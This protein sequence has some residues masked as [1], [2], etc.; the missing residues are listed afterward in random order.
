MARSTDRMATAAGVVARGAGSPG[1]DAVAGI[2]VV[3][4][5]STLS[6]GDPGGEVPVPLTP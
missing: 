4:P 2:D 3:R 1:F 5:G 6:A